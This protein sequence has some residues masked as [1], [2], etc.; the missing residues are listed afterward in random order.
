ML[1]DI[2]NKK[3]CGGSDAGVNSGKLGCL[4]LFGTPAHLMALTKGTVL[5]ATDTFNDAYLRPLVQSGTI[6]P[7]IDATEFEDVS[8]EDAYS[9]N[10]RGIKRLNVKGLPEY[11]L[12]FEEGHEFYRQ[13]AKMES[14]KRFDYL[15]GDTEGNWIVATRSDGDFQG[16]TSGHTT[17]ELTKR[18]VEGGDSEMKNLLVQFTDRLQWD[19]NYGILHAEDLD[20]TPQEIPV[21]NGTEITYTTV[22]ADTDTT[23]DVKVTLASDRDSLVEGLVLADFDVQVDGVQ[24]T[25]TLL[26]ETTPG[27]YTLTVTAISSGDVVTVSHFGSNT[28]VADS[29]GVLY[30]NTV[31]NSSTVV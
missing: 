29:N 9:T 23:I 15:I 28:V 31:D 19:E 18:K 3:A 4:S 10:T 30:R 8:S 22:P 7:L 26:A 14:Y 13:L 20:L 6:I 16:M 24:N 27:N 11:K 1:G 2:V 17:P 21:I 5:A 12:T 25:I